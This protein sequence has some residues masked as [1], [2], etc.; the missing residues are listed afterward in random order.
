VA[1]SRDQAVAAARQ[2]HAAIVGLAA[3][4][5]PLG[6]ALESAHLLAHNLIGGVVDCRAEPD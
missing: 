5:R 3:L 6:F 2:A 1:V 4:A